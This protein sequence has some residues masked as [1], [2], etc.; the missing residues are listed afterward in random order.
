[1]RSRFLLFNSFDIIIFQDL[2]IYHNNRFPSPSSVG[3]LEKGAP[4]GNHAVRDGGV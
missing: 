4:L 1:M 2:A 3:A